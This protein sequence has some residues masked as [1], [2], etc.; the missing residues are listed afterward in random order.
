MITRTILLILAFSLP[1]LAGGLQAFRVIETNPTHASLNISTRTTIAV[2]FDR[3]VDPESL[4]T[5]TR[6][7]NVFGRWSGPSAGS[8]QFINDNATFLFTPDE[9]FIAGENVFVTLS[10]DIMADDGSQLRSAGYGFSFWTHA[11]RS[12]MNFKQEQT[13]NVRTIPSQPTQAYGGIA[14]DLNNDGYSD[15][16]IVNEITADLRVFM[17]TAGGEEYFAPFIQPTSPV[18]QRA[19]PSEPADFNGDGNIDI[20]VANI[21]VNS[22]S[23]LL[24]NGDGTF[25]NQIVIPVGSTPRGIAVLD[26][27][28]DGDPDIANTNTAGNNVSLIENLGDGTFADAT[29]FEGGGNGE[30]SM[31]AAD[32]NEDGITDLVIGART[33]QTMIVQLGNGDGTFT[34]ASS[35]FCGGRTWMIAVGDVNGDGHED[36]VSANSQTNNASV[37]FG[38]GKGGLSGLQTHT[39]GAF[40]L[41]TDLGDLD[42]DGDLDWTTSSFSGREWRVFTNNGAGEFAMFDTVTAPSAGSCTL[43][44]DIDNDGDNDLSLIDEIADVVLVHIN[45]GEAIFGDF[46]GGGFVSLS[47]YGAFNDCA[48]AESPNVDCEVFDGDLDGDVDFVDFGHFQRSFTGD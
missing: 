21:D 7:F 43:L 15:M 36:I 22:V 34:F 5:E 30:W 28:G 25:Q 40:C 47:D 19:S 29:F 6:A 11:R 46:D 9:P 45:S 31:M 42:G 18:G 37:L 2:T 20:C 8:I 26:F 13:L 44:H 48:A 10:H 12:P 1:S 14:S 35:T 39:T 3:A 17:N 24:G 23:V 33:S 4:N 32:M 41:A 16:T 27:D 38:D